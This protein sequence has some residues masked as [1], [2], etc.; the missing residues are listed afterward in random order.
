MHGTIAWLSAAIEILRFY[1]FDLHVPLRK[2]R[3]G[4]MVQRNRFTK[5]VGDW[6][7]SS[8]NFAFFE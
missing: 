5:P 1:N 4:A 2:P 7:P 8:H 6:P 3:A